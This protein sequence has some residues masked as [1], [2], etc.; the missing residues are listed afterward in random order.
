MKKFRTLFT[1]SLCA[2]LMSFPAFAAETKAEYKEAV[3]PIKAEMK[4]LEA[5]MK[6]M[7]EENKETAA[8]YKAVR[9]TKKENGSLNISKDAWKE[10][11]QLHSKIVE[12]R[13]DM[14][15]INAKELR[16]ETKTAVKEKNFDTA[17]DNMEQLLENKRTRCESL[18]EINKLWEEIDKLLD[19]G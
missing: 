7:R 11:K 16:Q 18:T 12:I 1:A 10:A 6:P 8:R 14:K 15:K 3:A 17:I 5:Q 2:C 13:K 19:E 9:L 4:E